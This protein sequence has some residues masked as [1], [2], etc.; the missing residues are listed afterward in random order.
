MK[1]KTRLTAILLSALQAV[2]FSACSSSE[3]L[4]V[5]TGTAEESTVSETEAV[6]SALSE[7]ETTEEVIFTTKQE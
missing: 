3:N 1:I 7:S 5:E 6:A 4:P 2:L